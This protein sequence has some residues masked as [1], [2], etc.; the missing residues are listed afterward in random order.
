VIIAERRLHGVQFV[1]FCDALD[2]GDVRARGLA[3]QHGAGLYRPAIDMDDA[4]A[5]LAG[6]AADMGAGQ[7]QIFAQE[8]DEKGPVF[9]FSRDGLPF[10]VSLTVDTRGTSRCF[11]LFQLE[12]RERE[13]GN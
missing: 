13:L 10:T 7:V 4:G 9:D 3:G 6:V 12:T 2:G 11:I 8:M 1:A 5:A